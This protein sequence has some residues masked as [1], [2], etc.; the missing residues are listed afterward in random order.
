MVSHN[1]VT[2]EIKAFK[3][4][5]SV[6]LSLKVLPT[7]E[8]EEL[9]NALRTPCLNFR[10]LAQEGATNHPYQLVG[11]LMQRLGNCISTCMGLSIKELTIAL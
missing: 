10:L 9:P 8:V 3:N 1:G 2:G 7:G 11:S 6:E 5:A 4:G